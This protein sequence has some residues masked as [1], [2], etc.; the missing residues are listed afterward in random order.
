[1]QAMSD[2]EKRSKTVD[3]PLPCCEHCQKPISLQPLVEQSIASAKLSGKSADV[4]RLMMKGLS[5]K[6]IAII[7]GNS[8]KTI[9]SHV[10]SIF[11]RFGVNGRFELMHL[12]F[13]S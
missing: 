12:I 13:P 1:M 8:E 5:G 10:A 11:E 9:K 2:A 4:L 3:L 7:L 6:E